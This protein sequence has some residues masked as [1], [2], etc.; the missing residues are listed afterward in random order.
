MSNRLIHSSRSHMRKILEHIPVLEKKKRGKQ[1]VQK[2]ETIPKAIKEQTW[3]S[4]MG[5]VF[6]A[7]CFVSW[8]KNEMNVFDFHTGHNIPESKGGT[9]DISNLRPIC[10]R[11][12]LSM[13]AK[14]TITEWNLLGP[15][16]EQE[17][18]KRGWLRLLCF[19]K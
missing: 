12:N 15:A 7:K 16:Q 19:K 11:C 18:P 9:L 17:Q 8:C 2:K 5:P 3:L 10:A 4:H 6:K 13:G 14:Y 1:S